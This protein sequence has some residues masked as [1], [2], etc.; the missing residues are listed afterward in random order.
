VGVDVA[1]FAILI[2]N[3]ALVRILAKPVDRVV[4]DEIGV[5]VHDALIFVVDLVFL[6]EHK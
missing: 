1:V 4:L 5:R 6:L 3:S 2:E